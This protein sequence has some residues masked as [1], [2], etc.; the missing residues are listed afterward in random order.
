MVSTA[1][2]AVSGKRLS[3]GQV[4]DPLLIP[5]EELVIPPA[6]MGFLTRIWAEH[7]P[8]SYTHHCLVSTSGFHQ[9][10]CINRAQVLLMAR[11]SNNQEVFP[12]S[13]KA[14]SCTFPELVLMV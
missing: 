13:D 6:I 14:G 1:A 4:A 8:V 10:L 12:S 11:P 3:D 7:L 9:A 5:A 2:G